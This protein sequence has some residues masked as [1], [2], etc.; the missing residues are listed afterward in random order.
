MVPRTPAAERR[1][2][3]SSG[4]ALPAALGLLLAGAATMVALFGAGQV[5]VAKQRLVDTADAAAWSAGLWR[6]RVLNYHAYSNRAI[7][8]NEVAIAQAV[9][10]LSWARYFET[11]AENAATIASVFPPAR[12]VLEGVEQAAEYARQAAELAAEIEIPARGAEAVGYKEI[13]QL[14]QEILHLS[15][16]G[17]G[18]SMVAA[19][20]A[21][22]NRRD[23]FAWVLPEATDP[24]RD[25]TR[26]ADT[27]DERRRFA[28]LVV[29]SLDPFT[30][31][32]RSADVPDLPS[33]PCVDQVR[34]RKRGGTVLSDTLDRWEAADT[35][36]LHLP[37]I[38]GLRCRGR[39]AVPLGWGAAEAGRELGDVVLNPGDVGIN[40][41]AV[42]LAGSD[43]ASISGYAGIT[44]VRELDH[45]RL[46][47]TR[48]PTSRVAVLAREPASSVGTAATRGLAAGRVL[49]A[50]RFAGDGTPRL[51]AL[52][53]AQ[54]YF[55]RPAHAPARI[56]YASLFSPYWQVRLVE[57]LAAERAAAMAHV[58]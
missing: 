7:L 24:W 47:D 46:A 22:A 49:V 52:S 30:S 33:L 17:F 18:L 41:L 36:S 53:A 48:F 31:G 56:E 15:A 45:D 6:A 40:P 43:I 34:L 20:V 16:H 32:P 38:R 21:R 44:R 4:Q 14:S 39:E 1:T 54:V 3:R 10:L 11:L 19:E 50:E 55:R 58:R 42:A 8:A 12:A 27:V 25:F 28:D 9:T 37:S 23:A 57:P 2:S 29:A 5:T 13:L 51:W 26:R 35:V